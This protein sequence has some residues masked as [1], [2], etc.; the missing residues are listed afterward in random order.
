MRLHHS[1]APTGGEGEGRDVRAPGTAQ[2]RRCRRRRCRQAGPCAA[3]PP[4][5]APPWRSAARGLVEASGST[6][7][8]AAALRLRGR[9]GKARPGAAGSTRVGGT[10]APQRAFK[11]LNAGVF[12]RQQTE[13]GRRSRQ[14]SG[15][16]NQ[17]SELRV[18]GIYYFFGQSSSWSLENSLQFAL[19]G[20][21]GHTYTFG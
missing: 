5:S 2:P 21:L 17:V 19:L 1:A 18:I 3:A 9:V 10:R 13:K 20:S 15:L 7:R 4:V 11:Y 6:G 8:E 14:R 16:Q 12:K